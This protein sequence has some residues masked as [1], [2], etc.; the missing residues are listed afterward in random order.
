VSKEMI[1]I[2]FTDQTAP[3]LHSVLLFS[4]PPHLL[5][6]PS[7]DT[8]L[9]IFSVVYRKIVGNLPMET[10]KK[11]CPHCGE[12]ILAVATKCKHCKSDLTNEAPTCP[13]CSE[14]ISLTDTQCPHCDEELQPSSIGTTLRKEAKKEL[15]VI[16]VVIYLIFGCSAVAMM[17]WLDL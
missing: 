14:D 3:Q 12:D 2:Q 4:F 11:N 9:Y 6:S 8:I 17:V 10:K 5:Y 16:Q 1:A 7:I 15:S 13:F